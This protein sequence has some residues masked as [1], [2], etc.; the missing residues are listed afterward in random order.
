MRVAAKTL[1]CVRVYLL[2]MIT[3]MVIKS[4]QME[5][6]TKQPRQKYSPESRGLSVHV[7]M[8]CPEENCCSCLVTLTPGLN[9]A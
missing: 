3:M 5:R 6:R 4:G 2:H 9:R 8:Q 7:H 1:P